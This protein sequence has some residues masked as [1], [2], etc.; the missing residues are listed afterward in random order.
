MNYSKLVMNYICI[1]LEN[2][3]QLHL[4]KKIIQEITYIYTIGSY[5][6]DTHYNAWLLIN[7]TT[8]YIIIYYKYKKKWKIIS[9]QSTINKLSINQSY[10][11]YTIYNLNELY[12]KIQSS[13]NNIKILNKILMEEQNIHPELE[14]TINLFNKS[15]SNHIYDPSKPIIQDLFDTNCRNP[16]NTLVDKIYVINLDERQDRLIKI[17]QDFNKYN[18]TN[19]KRIGGVN[20]YKPEYINIWKQLF[21][22]SNKKINSPG[23]LGYLLSMKKVLLDAISNKY[24]KILIFDDDII[25]HKNIID[26]LRNTIFPNYYLLYLGCSQLKNWNKV[27]IKDGF[28]KPKSTNDGSFA[29]MIDNIIFN[30]LINLINT[31]L[32]PFDTGP[33]RHIQNKYP[34]Y[35]W[36]MYPNII[37]A[38]VRNSDIRNEG[39]KKYMFDFAKKTR[40]E[41][42]YY[43]INL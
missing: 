39:G 11:A 34:D 43:D 17:L 23:V 10:N 9:N 19:F 37:I 24:N 14:T 16:L 8:L 20:G 13:N 7:N 38:D 36:V 2:I 29:I 25:F 3:Y 1:Q 21:I 42:T 22:K 26:I 41:L 31:S 27:T 33:L 15:I 30:E 6:I 40:W 32:L 5:K 35:C 28:Y 18:I 4:I 12:T